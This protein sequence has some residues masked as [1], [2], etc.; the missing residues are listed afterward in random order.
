MF[1]LCAARRFLS[2][3]HLLIFLLVLL[4]I[5]QQCLVNTEK[6]VELSLPME[7]PWKAGTLQDG[8]SS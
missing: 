4:Q 5:V 3:G 8:V 6:L 1:K 2:Q 7:S